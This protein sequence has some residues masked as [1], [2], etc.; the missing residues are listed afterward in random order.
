MTMVT[1]TR[2]E[3]IPY[4]FINGLKDKDIL[5]DIDNVCSY[6]V[7]EVERVLAGMQDKENAAAR[8]E[9]RQPKPVEWDGKIRLLKRSK[10]GNYYFP[11]G[12][13]DRV[14]RVLRIYGTDFAVN[15]GRSRCQ[16]IPEVGSCGEIELRPYQRDALTKLVSNCYNASGIISLPTGAGKTIIALFWARMVKGPF[17]V[18]VH[19]KELL[20]QWHDEI[21]RL[22]P[23]IE[24]A[25][26]GAGYEDKPAFATVA[27]V[28]TLA[29]IV[30]DGK[31][32][33][34]TDLLIMD[35]CFPYE[36]RVITDKGVL[37][38]GDIVE[39][40]IDCSVLTHSGE[41]KRVSNRFSKPVPNWMVRVRFGNSSVVSTLSHRYLTHRGWI[42][43]KD[44]TIGDYVYYADEADIRATKQ[45]VKSQMGEDVIGRAEGTGI[46]ECNKKECVEIRGCSD[47]RGIAIDLRESD[48]GYVNSISEQTQQLSKIDDSPLFAAVAVCGLEILHSESV[49]RFASETGKEW[50][51]WGDELCVHNPVSSI[52][53]GCLCDSENRRE[54]KIHTRLAQQNNRT[55]WNCGMVFRRWAQDAKQRLCNI[56]GKNNGGGGVYS[57][58]LVAGTMGDRVACKSLQEGICCRDLS[59]G[60][61][62]QVYQNSTGIGFHPSDDGIQNRVYDLEV[63]DDHSYTANGVVVHNCHVIPAKNAYS[64]G[65]AFQAKYRLG[66][67]ATPYRTDG[68]DLKIF[69]CCGEKASVVTVEDLVSGGH[70]ARPTFIM[71]KIPAAD[72][73]HYSSWSN[74]V[75]HGITANASRNQAIE[76]MARKYLKE[77]RQVYIHVNQIMHGQGLKRRLEDVGAEWVCGSTPKK[78]R[79]RIIED[80]K[81]GKIPC[82]VSTLLKEGVSIDGISCLIYAAGGKSEV[83][84]IQTIGRALRKDP[85]FDDAIIIDF[86]DKGHKYLEEHR[87][88]RIATYRTVYGLLFEY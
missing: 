12:L 17:W 29:N 6:E 26:I 68:E 63:E 70:I 45:C 66:L 44:L 9:G 34:E 67:S 53:K 84:T 31:Q 15:D 4:F 82:L 35:E 41:F 65:M 2:P 18:L 83:A 5:E 81:A 87:E 64:V 19:R 28:Q 55:T 39:R 88:Q 46:Q 11:F 14:I 54:S 79:T 27:M 33:F 42:A 85:K 76:D 13:V 74:V 30:K 40:G 80:Y 20:D 37:Q 52:P 73:P 23:G 38:I 56:S 49:L 48:G 24:V 60:V 1:L 47:G 58:K 50:G 72:L 77:G 8:L 59:N 71:A 7:Q 25:R 21:K 69:A 57:E 75:R 16:S 32:K 3:N 51:I 22:Y 62:E 61:C 78:E 43:A 86:M 36:T 10:N